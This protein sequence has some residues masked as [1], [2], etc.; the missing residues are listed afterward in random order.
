MTERNGGA[1]TNGTERLAAHE[2]APAPASS[3]P[4]N[5]VLAVVALADLDTVRR[6]RERLLGRTADPRLGSVAAVG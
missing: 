3:M 5:R 2:C 4:V 1:S 6:R